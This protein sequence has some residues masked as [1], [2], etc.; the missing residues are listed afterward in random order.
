MLSGKS[1]VG[2]ITAFDSSEF[3]SHIAAEVKNFVP[4]DHVGRKAARHM[5][6]YAQL[7]VVAADEAIKDAQVP[8]DPAFREQ[9]GTIIATGIG[10]VITLVKRPPSGS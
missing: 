8:E 7:A 3:P 2:T 6:R 1:G 4:E 10:G 5:D 9:M